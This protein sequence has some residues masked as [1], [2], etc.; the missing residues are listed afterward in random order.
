[1]SEALDNMARRVEADPAFLSAPLALYARSAGLDDEALCTVLRCPPEQW[2]ALRL[3]RAPDAEPAAAFRRDVQAI[4]DR[5]GL[6][7]AALAAAVRRGQVLLRLRR[8]NGAG[9]LL[10]AR[11]RGPDRPDGGGA[12]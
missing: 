2:T 9:L 10:A 7:A 1:M 4:A 12:A 5:F 3:C 11:A 6:D 8:T